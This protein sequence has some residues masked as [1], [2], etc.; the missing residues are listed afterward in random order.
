V[1]LRALPV[2]M[3]VALA[4]YGTIDCLLASAD[5]VRGPGRGTWVALCL[6]VP[7]LGPLA[8]LMTGRP[9]R[10]RHGR[11]GGPDGGGYGWTAE[12]AAGHPDAPIGPDDDPE[13]ISSLSQPQ[14]DHRRDED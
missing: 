2:L 12:G 7:Y 3:W 5:E 10:A 4:V 11:V 1:L 14:R 13:F 6:L 9:S 8:W